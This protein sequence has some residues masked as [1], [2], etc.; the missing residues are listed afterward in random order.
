MKTRKSKVTLSI[1][2]IY[3]FKG[4]V[5]LLS[6][7]FSACAMRKEMPWWPNAGTLRAG[8]WLKKWTSSPIPPCLHSRQIFRICFITRVIVQPCTLPSTFELCCGERAISTFRWLSIMLTILVPWVFP[9]YCQR[10]FQENVSTTTCIFWLRAG[11]TNL[12]KVFPDVWCPARGKSGLNLKKLCTLKKQY[13]MNVFNPLPFTQYK[14]SNSLWARVF[15][16]TSELLC[17]ASSCS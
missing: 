14:Y 7:L 12:S 13:G 6:Y 9:K 16:W 1:L 8:K 4:E 3:L 15:K 10:C 5:F 17:L 11:I 2:L